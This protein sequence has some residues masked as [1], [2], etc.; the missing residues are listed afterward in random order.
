[1]AT[2]KGLTTQSLIEGWRVE[3]FEE[4]GF[5][6]G[7]ANMLAQRRVNGWLVSVHEVREMLQKGCSTEL[8]LKI[9]T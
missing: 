2:G 6:P 1:M 5:D 4:M 9:V 7:D 3:M 8:A